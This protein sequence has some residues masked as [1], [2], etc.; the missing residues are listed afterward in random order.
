MLYLIIALIVLVIGGIVGLFLFFRYY[1][2]KMEKPDQ[3]LLLLNQNL[4]HIQNAVD[5]RLGE[6]AR[7]FNELNQELGGVKEIGHQMRSLQDFLKSP[8]LRGNIGEEILKDLLKQYF[9]Q[10]CFELQYKF[11]SGEKVDAVI[12]TKEGIIPVDA[13]FPMENFQKMVQAEEEREREKGFK[14][15]IRDVKKHIKDISGKYIV[16][17]EGTVDFAIMYIPSEA[18]YYEIIRSGLELSSYARE[19]KIY[20]ASPNSFYYF[21]RII[22]MSMK[23]EQIQKNAKKIMKILFAAQ[24]DAKKLEE[25]LSLIN[26]HL[27]N[28]RKCLDRANNDYAKLSSKLDQAELLE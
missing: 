9:P 12:K 18:I 19:R 13:K 14:D 28:A 7:I 22:M 15:F 17:Q 4:Q 20:F 21:L 24:K 16:P 1:W 5:S 2:K 6:A 26:T 8:K 25:T 11:N 3:S 23:G 10:D 27:G